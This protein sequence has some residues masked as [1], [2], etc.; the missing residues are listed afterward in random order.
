[1]S[2]RPRVCAHAH[3]LQSQGRWPWSLGPRPGPLRAPRNRRGKGDLMGSAAAR[4]PQ[5]LCKVVL[6]CILS[7]SPVLG[8]GKAWA[9]ASFWTGF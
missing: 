6:R 5:H 4:E 7:C 9:R 8:G 1:M 2:S 3:L